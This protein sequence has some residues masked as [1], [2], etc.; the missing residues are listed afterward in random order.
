MTPKQAP[1]HSRE[2]DKSKYVTPS[3]VWK[4]KT[5]TMRE[6]Q[7]DFEWHSDSYSSGTFGSSSDTQDPPR[8]KRVNSSTEPNMWCVEGQHQIYVDARMLNDH[9]KMAHIIT[10]EH[11]ILTGLELDFVQILIAE[12]HERAFK[13]TTTLPFPCLIFHLCR[14]VEVPIW[15]CD[16]LMEVTKTM[17]ASLIRDDANLAAPQRD[18]QVD[19]PIF[20]AD[21]A[22]FVEQIETIPEDAPTVEEDEVVMTAL[23][24]DTMPPPDTS[25][26]AGKHHHPSD[27]TID[28]KE[29]R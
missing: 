7:S 12:I 15:H 10:K 19:L 22:N 6:S 26:A 20:G 17:D 23:F 27:H 14:A 11:R 13:T 9:Q 5:S 29:A 16:R 21:L 8:A 1:V 4:M 3:N 25:R 18:P 28:T 2:E 24:D